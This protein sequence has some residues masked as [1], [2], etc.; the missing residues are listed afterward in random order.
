MESWKVLTHI[1]FISAN[2]R[3]RK[4]LK[5]KRFL[6]GIIALLILANFTVFVAILKK[7]A[8]KGRHDDDGV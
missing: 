6:Q 8:K 5:N 3:T 7:K 1:F 4:A 2:N